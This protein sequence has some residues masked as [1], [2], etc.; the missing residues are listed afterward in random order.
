[1]LYAYVHGI[2]QRAI[3]NEEGICPYGHS[4]IPKCGML[5]CWHWAHEAGVTCDLWQDGETEW[6]LRWK[7]LFPEGWVEKIVRQ[8]L[9][10]EEHEWIEDARR[11]GALIPEWML[12]THI[13]DVQTPAGTVVEF[14]HS[15]I[16]PEEIAERNRFYGSKL[17]WVFDFREI[18]EA[19]RVT[20]RK[21]NYGHSFRWRW[22]KKSWWGAGENARAVFWDLG[23][24]DLFLLKK[25]YSETPCGGW[26]Q[27]I[28]KNKWL[29]IVMST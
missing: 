22:P 19:R 4:M 25:V 7:A 17:I 15:S 29:S 20:F 27:F 10:K 23:D 14:Q 5:V 3:P 21:Q 18:R 9:Q 26:G 13:A 2:K 24:E 28:D 12:E 8:N 1:M 6:H 11:Y 16:S